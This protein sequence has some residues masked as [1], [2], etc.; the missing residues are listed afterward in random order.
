MY[1]HARQLLVVEV[2]VVEG[3]DITEVGQEIDDALGQPVE[4]LED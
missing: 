4:P 2:S 3:R 1:D